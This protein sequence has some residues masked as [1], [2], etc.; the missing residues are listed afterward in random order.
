TCRFE[1]VHL[2][3]NTPPGWMDEVGS[4]FSVL[5][6]FS[7]FFLESESFL[8][9]QLGFFGETLVLVGHAG[10][11]HVIAPRRRLRSVERS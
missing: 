1:I 7:K 3:N 9:T 4:E 11:L 10:L 5:I 6:A 2:C 8:L